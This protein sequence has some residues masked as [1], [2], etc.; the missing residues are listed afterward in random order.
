[1][2]DSEKRDF[3]QLIELLP[4]LKS[5]AEKAS[6][7]E[8]LLHQLEALRIEELQSLLD[9]ASLLDELLEKAKASEGK[10]ENKPFLELPHPRARKPEEQPRPIEWIWGKA[11]GYSEVDTDGWNRVYVMQVLDKEGTISADADQASFAVTVIGDM[12]IMY[13]DVIPIFRNRFP[14]AAGPTKG[15]TWVAFGRP[16]FPNNG[17]KFADSGADGPRG[18]FPLT[19]RYMDVDVHVNSH[20]KITDGKLDHNSGTGS[21]VTISFY[22]RDS[23]LI[24]LKYDEDG[25][26]YSA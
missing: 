9:K 8:G 13:G 15:D 24:V 22:D 3:D 4:K 21:L 10:L 19:S 20:L 14:T 2:T 7:I 17:L 23:N 26:Y 18:A 16:I 11:I 25:H 1:M 6:E 12:L 5:L